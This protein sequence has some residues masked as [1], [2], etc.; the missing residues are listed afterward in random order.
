[1][2][3]PFLEREKELMKLNESLNTKMTFDFMKKQQ[4]QQQQPKAITS[5]KVKKVTATTAAAT[6][7]SF[8]YDQINHAKLGTKGTSKLKTDSCEIIKKPISNTY[9]SS[10]AAAAATAAT[11][12]AN[13]TIVEKFTFVEKKHELDAKDIGFNRNSSTSSIQ[14]NCNISRRCTATTDNTHTT[15]NGDIKQAMMGGDDDDDDNKH[16]IN[17]ENFDHALI[18]TIEKAIDTNVVSK[19]A[20]MAATAAHLSL[21]PANMY[22][23]NIS[24]DGIIK[25]CVKKKISLLFSCFLFFEIPIVLI[26]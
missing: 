24:T 16:Q 14:S 13:S 9:T 1:M 2:P 19:T 4:Q 26:L 23:K 8:K 12:V 21:I 11:V 7:K 3:D 5:N 10:T 6:A 15:C 18:E 25:Y 17:N 22:R 20:T